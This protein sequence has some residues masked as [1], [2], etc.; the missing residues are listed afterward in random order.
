M[1]VMWISGSSQA[2]PPTI[3]FLTSAGVRLIWVVLL[4]SHFLINIFC[5]YHASWSRAYFRALMLLTRLEEGVLTYLFGR[6]CISTIYRY[7]FM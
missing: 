7:R 1:C 3:R 5:T 6:D 4:H 2:C